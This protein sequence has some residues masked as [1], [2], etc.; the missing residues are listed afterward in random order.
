MTVA[1]DRVIVEW[2]GERCP[3]C[4]GLHSS[5]GVGPC[6]HCGGPAQACQAFMCRRCGWHESRLAIG[7]DDLAR[8]IAIELGHWAP[9]SYDVGDELVN[10]DTGAV[11][12]I[13]R[14]DDDAGHERLRLSCDEPGDRGWT[15]DEL[16]ICWTPSL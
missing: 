10:V 3:D 2:P 5:R 15:R 12:T 13:A 8:G 9:A 4:S 14:V 6:A 7:D 1:V 11:A 16:A